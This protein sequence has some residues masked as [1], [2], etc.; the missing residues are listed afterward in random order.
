MDS[1][2]LIVPII[3]DVSTVKRKNH[4]NSGREARPSNT[5]YLEKQV[6]MDSPKVI[7]ISPNSSGLEQHRC[8]EK[9]HIV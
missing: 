3:N 5:A 2:G 7:F 9:Q 1:V 6:L 8:L 4:Q